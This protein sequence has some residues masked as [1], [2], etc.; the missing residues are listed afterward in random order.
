MNLRY[1]FLYFI[2]RFCA[3]IAL[4]AS[5]TLC[6]AQSSFDF[7]G[8][9]VL[10]SGDDLQQGSVYRYTGVTAGT[11]ALV[12]VKALFNA[13]LI[14]L[15]A[16]AGVERA[17]QP[18]INGDS[19]GSYV[20]FRV[21][22]VDSGTSSASPVTGSFSALDIDSV[23]E[24]DTFFNVSD[25]T[26]ET[27][28]DLNL[29]VSSS[30]TL[31]VTGSGPDYS[32]ISETNT[33]A[34][35]TVSVHELAGFTYRAGVNEDATRQ[36]SLL[37]E[38]VD[39][40]AA[41]FTNVNDAP[42]AVA[43]T[44]TI[45]E[46]SRLTVAAENGL[47]ANDSDI[48]IGLDT[49]VLVIDSITI[50]ASSY[51]TS[52]SIDLAEGALTVNSNGSY[53]FIPAPNYSGSV[54]V[55]SYQVSDG[56]GGTDTSTL[57]LLVT[58]GGS[59]ASS[60]MPVSIDED[61]DNNGFI[62]TSEISGQINVSV[63]LPP[64]AVVGDTI[65]TVFGE[66][67]SETVI[68]ANHLL[69][70]KV[71]VAFSAPGDGELLQVNASLT[72]AAGNQ[73]AIGSD[74]A[75]ID[76]T[77]TEAPV[78]TISTDIDNSGFISELENSESILVV[79]ELPAGVSVNDNLTII[80][81]ITS[82]EIILTPVDIANGSVSTTIP[83][84]ADGDALSVIAQ[85]TDEA[86]NKS[87]KGS[88]SVM[89]DITAPTSP[90][91]EVLVSASGTPRISGTLPDNSNYLLSV[92]VNGVVYATGD[93]QLVE[94]SGGLWV[95]N[96]PANDALPDGNYD[97]IVVVTD[98]A[99]NSTS[100][101]TTG[102]LTIDL[103][104]PELTANNVGPSSDN[105]P[106]LSGN[107][108]Q[109]DGA[110]VVVTTEDGARVCQAILQENVWSCAAQIPLSIGTNALVATV[111]DDA[112]NSAN[113][114]FSVMVAAATDT[115][116]DGIPD[117]IETTDDS[118]NDGIPNY[119]DLDSDNDTIADV[120]ET[121][122][123][124]D[125][126]GVRNYLDLDSDN[127]GL[128]DLREARVRNDVTDVE[129]RIDTAISVGSNG[130]ADI[131]ESAPD[132]GDSQ[133]PTDTDG[134]L[135]ADFIDHDS[136]NDG[137]S[138][139]VENG[140][141]DTD[142][143]AMRADGLLAVEL[144]FDSD[145]IPNYRDLDSDQDGIS[146]IRESPDSDVDGDGRVDNFVDLNHDGLAD[147]VAGNTTGVVGGLAQDFDA[148]GSAN[149]LDLDSDGD[150]RF[151]L[152]EAGGTD[153]NNDGIHDAYIDVNGNAV[154]DLIDAELTLGDDVDGDFIDDQFDSGFI[155]SVDADQDGIID[156]FDIDADGNG[157]ADVLDG[158]ALQLPD[159]N[160]DGR[161]DVYDAGTLE[162][163]PLL[164]TGVGGLGGGCSI[165]PLH[166]RQAEGPID[167]LFL[168]LLVLA[169]LGTQRMKVMPTGVANKKLLTSFNIRIEV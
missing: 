74:Q 145:S 77:S 87:P 48:D 38:S 17:L 51:P 63:Q 138:D 49:D 147:N 102:E 40:S 68:D 111:M 14:Q 108:D 148:D 25:Y 139:V 156:E 106:V 37:F 133:S 95:L 18:V 22:F 53:E 64:E 83:A 31:E 8:T 3:A 122:I 57:S 70:G 41:V 81:D 33:T 26:V 110:L 100:D 116:G 149:F 140:H 153:T 5:S 43:D 34:V 75:I 144:D 28:S 11:D 30:Q 29:S 134:D 154:P 65:S 91:V 150:G 39:F 163:E 50:G 157:Y 125:N 73:S 20:E 66:N 146:D 162:A 104:E 36:T 94:S 6:Y 107:S 80:S 82:V 168:Y 12:E 159:E 15:D 54:D 151:D 32:P 88:D 119:L 67:N 35:V 16:S 9:P 97:V 78:V 112:G 129:G 142:S 113:D 4:F 79:V 7:S 46:N 84:L 127:D 117:D 55:V 10:V 72:D 96:I 167:F 59:S 21:L 160:G 58:P 45:T 169:F 141:I 124:R 76:I 109:L 61:S 136:D 152:K 137:I 161:E 13:T 105:A 155:A 165:Q 89:I 92:Q 86:G 1:F 62:S 135:V 71:T 166:A 115:D 164:R 19:V 118:D 131:V 24:F 23:A 123:D 60:V 128:S 56:N 158:V 143:D 101:P 99:G 27:N 121:Q 44:N 85:V 120:L 47:L 114:S 130:L 126:D 90:S 103:Q 2:K 52:S 132:S 42:D 69:D 93:G 98:M